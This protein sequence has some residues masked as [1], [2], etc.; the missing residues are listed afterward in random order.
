MSIHDAIG[1]FI[2]VIRNAGC[3]G[4]ESCAFPHS[5]VREGIARILK[6]RGFVESF[7][8]AIDDKG[9]KNIQ[10]RLKYVEGSHAI[11]GISRASTPGL[12]SYC[13]YRE[14]PRV[15]DGLGISILSTPK[16]LLDDSSARR[17]KV[18][19][20]ILCNVW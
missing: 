13:G 12:R 14:I 11:K 18:G 9:W 5:K 19:G 1:D 4:K 2:T 10:V 6:D 17:Q 16:G 7:G 8:E 20:E 15:L 3:A